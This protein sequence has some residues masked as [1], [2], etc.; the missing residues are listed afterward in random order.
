[1]KILHILSLLGV[2]ENFAFSMGS[3]ENR[4]PQINNYMF[5]QQTSQN[6][7]VIKAINELTP[8]FERIYDGIKS[9]KKDVE[10]LKYF[11][12]KLEKITFFVR[13]VMS[14][15]MAVLPHLRVV[16]LVLNQIPCKNIVKTLIRNELESEKSDHS[17]YVRN[18]ILMPEILRSR[19]SNCNI[20]NSINIDEIVELIKQRIESKKI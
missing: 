5:E 15:I 12:N 6:D 13:P 19:L 4:F 18:Y 20:N 8:E 17:Q 14:A 9:S 16:S 3:N 7:E 2:L 10:K 1:M 11:D